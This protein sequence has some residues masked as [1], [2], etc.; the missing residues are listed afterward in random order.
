MRIV[1]QPI[2]LTVTNND[3][4]HSETNKRHG[5]LLPSTIRCLLVGPSNCGK[6]NT[7]ISLIEHSNGLRFENVYVYSKSLF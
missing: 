2:T 6:T 7:M 5:E 4:K 1:Q 3:L